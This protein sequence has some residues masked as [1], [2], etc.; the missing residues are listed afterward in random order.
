VAEWLERLRCDHSEAV[1][2]GSEPGSCDC[3]KSL[4]PGKKLA[5]TGASG[6]REMQSDLCRLAT[7]SLF[8]NSGIEY[9]FYFYKILATCAIKNSC[10]YIFCI[11]VT[12]L[13]I[14]KLKN[15]IFLLLLILFL[16][17][18][19][20]YCTNPMLYNYALTKFK[21]QEN[22]EF[23]SKNINFKQQKIIISNVA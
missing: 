21:H 7:T 11:P 15:A 14:T 6:I 12:L 20:S 9:K 8:W 13:L 23:S 22:S 2:A 4:V 16:N 1:R 3:K 5:Q 17:K 18:H 10:S 19:L